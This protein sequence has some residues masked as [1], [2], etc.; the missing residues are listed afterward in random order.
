MF[1]YKS[2]ILLAEDTDVT[3]TVLHKMLYKL[4]FT[5]IIQ[6]CDGTAAQLEIDRG[7]AQRKPIHVVISDWN[8]PGVSGLALLK[9]VRQHPKLKDT[10]FLILTSN[11]QKEQVVEAIQSGVSAYLTKPFSLESFETKLRDAWVASQ[12]D[13]EAA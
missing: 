7:V 3:R 10:P 8:M 6:V 2:R 11:N 1:P 4:G 13:K 12:K 9:Y 5:N